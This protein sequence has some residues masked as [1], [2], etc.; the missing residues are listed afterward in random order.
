MREPRLAARLWFVSVSPLLAQRKRCSGSSY[1][2][3]GSVVAGFAWCRAGSV[4]TEDSCSRCTGIVLVD[5]HAAVTDQG[6]GDDLSDL[7]DAR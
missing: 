7:A 1:L 3:Q 5:P 4:D 6:P 2:S